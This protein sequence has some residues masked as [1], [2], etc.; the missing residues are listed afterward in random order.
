VAF[1]DPFAAALARGVDLGRARAGTRRRRPSPCAASASSDLDQL[2]KPSGHLRDL[3]IPRLQLRG[4]ARHDDGQLVAGHL[5]RRGHPKIE[6]PPSRSPAD[7]HAPF[8]DPIQDQV[9]GA[10]VLVHSG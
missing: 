4:L 8:V 9:I 5:L 7:R 10:G 3:P 1:A 6:P 2:G